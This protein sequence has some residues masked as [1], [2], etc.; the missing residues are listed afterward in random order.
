MASTIPSLNADVWLH[1]I[2]EI[3][4]EKNRAKRISTL[5][6]IAQLSWFFVDPAESQIYREVTLAE[7]E[8]DD[9]SQEDWEKNVKDFFTIVTARPRPIAQYVESLVISLSPSHN[10]RQAESAPQPHFLPQILDLL[11]NVSELTLKRIDDGDS[12][13]WQRPDHTLL[14]AIGRM[15]PSVINLSLQWAPSIKLDKLYINVTSLPTVWRPDAVIKPSN[16]IEHHKVLAY[17]MTK[18]EIK[19]SDKV[20]E[21]LALLDLDSFLVLFENIQTLCLQTN[22]KEGSKKSWKIIQQ[23]PKLVKLCINGLNGSG[24][25]D[26]LDVDIGIIKNLEVLEIICNTQIHN[27]LQPLPPIPGLGEYFHESTLMTPTNIEGLIIRLDWDIIENYVCFATGFPSGLAWVEFDKLI[28]CSERFPCLKTLTFDFTIRTLSEVTFED[29]TQGP[30][31]L[32]LE[33]L[34]HKELPHI[35]QRGQIQLVVVTDIMVSLGRSMFEEA[36]D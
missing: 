34:T 18:L 22:G 32:S 15:L 16:K 19:A 3:G 1:I 14:D 12:E 6:T 9:A 20:I 25:I 17:P 21:Y 27:K 5:V 35:I 26:L 8:R 11:P 30:E 23:L 28:A 10:Q 29:K 7:D 4:H 33:N 31:I 13:L 36:W 24:N 2:K